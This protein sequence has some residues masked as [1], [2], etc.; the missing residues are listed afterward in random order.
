MD[1]ADVVEAAREM[2]EELAGPVAGLAMLREAE[3]GLQQVAGA[4]RNDARSREGER[5]AVVALQE[6]LVVEGVHL[7]RAAV[8]EQEQH[9]RCLRLEMRGPRRERIGVVA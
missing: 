2:R 8:H 6:R 1:H 5:L 7:R 3:G 4:A 9:A